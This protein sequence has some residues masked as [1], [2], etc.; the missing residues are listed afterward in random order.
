MTQ[1]Q[2]RL[3]RILIA[4]TNTI[5][6]IFDA[7]YTGWSP[8]F[9]YFIDWCLIMTLATQWGM[10]IVH[11]FPF[12]PTLSRGV[13]FLFQV[14]LPMT[15]AITIIYWLFFYHMGSMHISDAATYVH[16]IFLYLFPALFLVV[17]WWLNSIM[18]ESKYLLHMIII[19]LVYC[20]MT[21]FGKYALGYFPYFFITWDT[22][23]SYVTLLGLGVLC[24][25][26]FLC[27]SKLNDSV[28]ERYLRRLAEKQM[29]MNLDRGVY[30]ELQLNMLKSTFT[31]G[32]E[33]RS[34]A[35]KEGSQRVL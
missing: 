29:F 21:Y 7:S 5:T 28:K 11:F 8:F 1:N 34:S 22:F 18:F 15:S 27:F 26:L 10:V 6:G 12:H 19:Y 2:L 30:N 9:W 33:G 35:R 24:A 4:L 20:P 17:E 14:T 31:E 16:P 13:K 23:G 32:G 3:I 25:L